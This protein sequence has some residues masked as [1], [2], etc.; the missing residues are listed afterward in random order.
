MKVLAL[1]GSGNM[2]QV[3]VRTILRR[4]EVDQLVVANRN[5][6]KASSFVKSLKDK[7]VLACGI[8]VEDIN[9]LEW[10]MSKADIVMN[11]VGPDYPFAVPIIRSAIKV[12]C[13][14]IDMMA[15]PG[16]VQEVLVLDE[17]ARQAGVTVLIGMGASP[18]L[19][20]ILA[21]HAANQ[22]D[23]VDY[24]QTVGGYVGGVRAPRSALRGEE[25]TVTFAGQR[26]S[27]SIINFFYYAGWKIPV[28]CEG[29]P[30]GIFPLEDG[31]EVTFP[32][33]KGFFWY[34]GHGEVV[35]LPHFIK[36]LRGACNLVG[37][38]QEE[39]NV[40]REL[41]ARVRARELLPEQAAAMYQPEVFKKRQQRPDES[42]DMGPRVGGLYASASGK[43]GGIKLRYGYGFLGGPPGGMRGVTSIPFALATEMI[44]NGEITQRGVLAPEACIEPLPFFE[45]YM[46]YW[47][48]P[49]ESV[50][51]VLYEVFEEVNYP[52]A[53]WGVP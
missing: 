31:E 42:I 21:R 49:P 11:T 25:V 17:E 13:H 44:M 39:L 35:T 20:N 50:E 8:D 37:R 40:L 43:K 29:K 6:E 27:A 15:D 23:E 10:V 28:F 33:G 19:T 48:N 41:A 47:V 36:G 4:V 32:Q 46:K 34:Y 51:Q 24:I 26:I 52:P 9:A 1:G 30:T 3:G 14:Y 12:G 45:R 18:G 2:G 53:C 16:V 5:F 22:L 7:R 38:E